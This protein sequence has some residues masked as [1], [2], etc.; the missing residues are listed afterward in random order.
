MLLSF[1]IDVERDSVAKFTE[2]NLSHG[3]A[4]KTSKRRE[5]HEF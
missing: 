2:A 3:N 4:D 1:S 5:K